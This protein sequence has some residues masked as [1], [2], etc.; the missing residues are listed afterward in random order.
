MTHDQSV[1]RGNRNR[2]EERWRGGERE[3]E[4]QGEKVGML[5]GEK[6][7]LRIY[8][9]HACELVIPSSSAKG[10]GWVVV[11]S[12]ALSSGPERGVM[13]RGYDNGGLL[14]IL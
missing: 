9:R 12:L 14:S 13:V 11:A 2:R 8:M 3:R 5:K 1:G 4:R 6:T 7:K 10:E